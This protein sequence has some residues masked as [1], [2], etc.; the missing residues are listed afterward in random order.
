MAQSTDTTPPPTTINTVPTDP[1]IL[2]LKGIYVPVASGPDLGLEGID[3]NDGT[4]SK[5]LI[6]PVFGIPSADNQDQN[7]NNRIIKVRTGMA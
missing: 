1:F 4:Y 6:C 7:G 3:L 2:L 5:T